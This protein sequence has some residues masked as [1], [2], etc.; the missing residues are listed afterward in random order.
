MKTE[1]TVILK[2]NECNKKLKELQKMQIEDLTHI[3]FI[4]APKCNGESENREV[5]HG[6]QKDSGQR[7]INT[8]PT[9][10]KAS[11]YFS[12]FFTSF[13]IDYHKCDSP[14][15]IFSLTECIRCL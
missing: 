1:E 2:P 10:Y 14:W 12:F 15:Y 9:E 8:F 6:S 11:S 4:S 5:L 7:G 3:F 13:K